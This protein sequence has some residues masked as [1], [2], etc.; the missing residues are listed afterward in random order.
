M[1]ILKFGSNT[2]A[3]ADMLLKVAGIV[4]KEQKCIIVLSSIKGTA[5]ALSEISNYLY[6]KNQEGANEIINK[7]ELQ[8]FSLISNL[9]NNESIKEQA[10]SYLTNKINYIRSF[11]KDLFTLFEERVVMAQGELISSELF[12]YLLKEQNMDATILSALNFMRT[13]KNS[14]PDPVYI[15]EKLT[16]S[17][18]ENSQINYFITQGYIC[19]NA[20]GE[21]DDLRKGG[22]DYTAA[23]VGSAI[24]TQEI[25]IWSN[26]DVMQ[27]NDPRYVDKTE[28]IRLLSF[29]EAAEL[30][31]FGEKILHPTSVLPAKL[32]NIPV[33][34]KNIDNPN[35]PG[36]LISNET[37]PNTIKAVAAKE[38]ITAIKIKS[39]KMLLAHG[40]LRRVFEVF[41]NY[42]TSI[43]MLTTS[44]VGVSVT[45]DNIKNLDDIVDELKKYGTVSIDKDMVLVCVVGDL[46]WSNIGFQSK[47]LNA[48][49]DLAIRMI[50]YGGSNYNVSFLIRK[51]DKEK[52]LKLLNDK[53]FNN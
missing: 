17:L 19:R 22:S 25:Q 26:V 12:Y 50:S 21:I 30:T 1:K 8:Y 27:N 38:G 10:I 18:K 15:K 45:I 11:T 28:P 20:Y 29:D 6:K 3:T 5:E 2:I 24:D 32:A 44:E 7:L 4:S 34:L 43:D 42:Q 16:L 41:E 51:S 35:L 47:I 31:Y 48:V 14:V 36:T 13:D 37:I 9:F 49:K 40:F 23:L 53:L 46:N 39:G 52:A 33:H